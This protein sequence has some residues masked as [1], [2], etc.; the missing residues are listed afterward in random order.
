MKAAGI[1]VM[2]GALAGSAQAAGF[3]PLQP[4]QSAL[5]DTTQTERMIIALWVQGY[6]AADAGSAD[7]ITSQSVSDINRLLDANC[8]KTPDA[9]ILWLAKN[10]GHSAPVSAASD[11]AA[12]RA[13]LEAF[14]KPDAN[15]ADLT[16]A[17][18][19]TADDIHA[20]YGEPLASALVEAYAGL[21]KPGVAIGP[22][23]GQ[24]TVLMWYT[25]TDA[26][27][28]GDP[29]LGNFPGG[30]KDVLPY[31]NAG[32]PIVRFKFVTKGSETGM[33][34]DGLVFVNG[35]WVLMPKPWR[36]L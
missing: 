16:A 25:S 33:A 27:I 1:A 36:P 22:K 21:F 26:L 17:L 12:V 19:P 13:M 10:A 6:R 5:G 24:D 2:L 30:Y 20:V 4:C 15:R 7:A 28:S 34:F 9:S 18:A 3:D 29:V 23:A 14:L 32:F 31:M 35:R 8:A 11:E